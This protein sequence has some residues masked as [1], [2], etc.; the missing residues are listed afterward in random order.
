M[1][2]LFDATL[3][4]A[5]AVGR[6]YEG[7]ATDGGAGF[8]VD[9][10]LRLTRDTL[11]GGT[12]W[13][14]SGDNAGASTLVTDQGE[15]RIDFVDSGLAAVEPGVVYAALESRVPRALLYQAVRLAVQAAGPT[16][17]YNEDLETVALQAEYELP[18]AITGEVV[19]VEIA[20]LME[21]PWSWID[22]PYFTVVERTLRFDADVPGIS[23]FAIRVGHNEPLTSPINDD[24]ELPFGLNIER[25]G[26]E[27]AVHIWR[28]RLAE[29]E[30]ARSD[31]P[32]RDLMA[33]AMRNA[34]AQGS[35]AVH[36]RPRP[37]QL[38][39]F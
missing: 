25:L 9:Q 19:S 30:T 33:E 15:G 12:L 18:E 11:S 34:L 14:L 16:T 26:Y 8:L 36:R 7:T 13:F 39:G 24:D 17:L 2:T 5:R 22:H 27:A 10:G 20:A 21:A 4:A 23:G 35:H 1:A 31:H 3:G 32:I 6:V 29:V 28:L 38:M 37:I